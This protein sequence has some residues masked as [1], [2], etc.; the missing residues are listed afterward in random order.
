[1]ASLKQKRISDIS[2]MVDSSL[3]VLKGNRGFL[4]F[5]NISDSNTNLR[6]FLDRDSITE[7]LYFLNGYDGSKNIFMSRLYAREEKLD[8]L[9]V[10]KNYENDI[11]DMNLIV[12]D[13]LYE[14]YENSTKLNDEYKA[15]LSNQYTFYFV[16]DINSNNVILKNTKDLAVV[17]EGDY[18]SFKKSFIEYFNINVNLDVTAQA[19]NKLETDIENNYCDKIY[20]FLLENKCY[21]TLNTKIYDE[22]NNLLVGLIELSDEELFIKNDFV[23][24]RDGLTGLYNKVTITEMAKSRIENAKINTTLLIIDLD[25]FKEC[26]DMYGH[27]YGDKVILTAAKIIN[28]SVKN[29]GYAGRIGGDEFLCIIDPVDEETIRGVTKDI[30]LGIQWGI[31]AFNIDSVVTCSI[32]VARYPLNCDNYDDLFEYADKCLYIAKNKGRNNYVIY[33]PEIHDKVLIKND[34]ARNDII[35]GKY[36]VDIFNNEHEIT[37][38]LAAKKR[39]NLRLNQAI[40]DYFGVDKFTVY[41]EKL[42]LVI[43]AGKDDVNFRRDYIHNKDYFK[44]INSYGFLVMDN[45]NVLDTID[46]EK[47]DMY[48][49]D[50]ISS[51]IEIFRKDKHDKFA[52]LICLDKYKPAKTFTNEQILFA[53]HLAKLY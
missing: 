42:N 48:L 32:G 34:E 27:A 23:D 51:T 44:Y 9:F 10:V 29:I 39:D 25:K 19:F 49:S 31:E 4:R 8:C 43:S 21:L 5:L 17:F 12:V 16:Y 3:N 13:Y 1:M 28:D 36:F 26:N 15:V 2:F 37:N 6:F 22:N 35:S 18:L 33:K 40:L 47:Y 14:L 41:D 7:L 38:L 53:L 45:T 24:K 30:R 46:K 11:F 20:K 50:N 52:G